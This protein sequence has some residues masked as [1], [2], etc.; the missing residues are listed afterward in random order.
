MHSPI[1][2]CTCMKAVGLDAAR[3]RNSQRGHEFAFDE[4]AH[5][6]LM[7][8]VALQPGAR[9]QGIGQ[10]DIAVKEDAVPRHQHVVKNRHGVGLLEA[11]AERMIP[12]RLVA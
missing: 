2:S 8:G 5:C 3:Q 7:P 10:F 1:C 9:E 6:R 11:R 12:F 4:P